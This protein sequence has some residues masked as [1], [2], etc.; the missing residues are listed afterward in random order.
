MCYNLPLNQGHLSP[1][2]KCLHYIDLH[3]Y[4]VIIPY[5]S[6]PNSKIYAEENAKEPTK[7]R[8]G[9]GGRGR[10][11][12]CPTIMARREAPPIELPCE[13]LLM[14]RRA[15]ERAT[16]ASQLAVCMNQLETCVSW[17]KSNA[18]VVSINIIMC[19]WTNVIVGD[20]HGVKNEKGN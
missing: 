3:T 9:G 13:A 20:H 19:I 16:S 15:V 5:F 12:E 1:T 14:W 11:R 8:G 18:V 10:N 7:S 6:P 17:E 2:Q 4:Y